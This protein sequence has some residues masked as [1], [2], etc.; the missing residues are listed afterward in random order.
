MKKPVKIKFTSVP[1][2]VSG[3]YLWRQK[4]PTESQPKAWYMTD[5]DIEY[6]QTHP[7]FRDGQWCGPLEIEEVE[8]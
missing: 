1:P 6:Y 4:P 3:W 5:F 2:K 8:K 7:D